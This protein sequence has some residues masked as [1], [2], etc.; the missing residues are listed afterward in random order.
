MYFLSYSLPLAPGD[1][2]SLAVLAL[3]IA[4]MAGF[5]L[6]YGPRTFN[7]AL[8]P[9]LFRVLTVPPPSALLPFA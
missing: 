1:G 5:V 6:C 2:L 8:F 9:L 7:A 4:W 3:V